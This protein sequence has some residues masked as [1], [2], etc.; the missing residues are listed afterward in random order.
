MK[1]DFTMW[2]NVMESIAGVLIEMVRWWEEQE[3][4]EMLTVVSE[5][6]II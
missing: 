4:K 6:M 3:Q 2:N 5:T 1:M